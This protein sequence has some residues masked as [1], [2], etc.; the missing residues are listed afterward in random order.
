M[1]SWVRNYSF[2][3]TAQHAGLGPLRFESLHLELTSAREMDLPT[4]LSGERVDCIDDP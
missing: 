1:W 2:T 4:Q 3:D